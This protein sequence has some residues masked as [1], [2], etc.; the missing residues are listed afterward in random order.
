LVDVECSTNRHRRLNTKTDDP[1]NLSFV[2]ELPAFACSGLKS[3]P[4][5]G[6]T[7]T[8]C[9]QNMPPFRDAGENVYELVSQWKMV[10]L[11][12][13]AS[14]DPL[15][16]D[17]KGLYET[18]GLVGSTVVLGRGVQVAATG[19]V[20]LDDEK[21]VQGLAGSGAC[22][23]GTDCFGLAGS[24]GTATFVYL[25]TAGTATRDAETCAVDKDYV[26]E[27]ANTVKTVMWDCEN[28]LYVSQIKD[29]DESTP[30]DNDNALCNASWRFQKQPDLL[31]M[32]CYAA[33]DDGRGNGR[34]PEFRGA[35]NEGF[36]GVYNEHPTTGWWQSDCGCEFFIQHDYQCTNSIGKL[37]ITESSEE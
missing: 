9:N 2:S 13:D 25:P 17:E 27:V 7:L 23:C 33:D 24:I 35:S 4:P 22:S 28:H 14:C 5:C 31:C 10:D 26:Y 3:T 21:D 34:L 15:T 16:G 36:S 32:E 6:C 19:G 11:D 1:T 30:C 20:W 37:T 12:Y 18:I 29:A 8:N